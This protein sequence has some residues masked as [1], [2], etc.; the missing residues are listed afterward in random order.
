MDHSEFKD[1][2][3]RLQGRISKKNSESCTVN[4]TDE[5]SLRFEESNV[6][7]KGYLYFIDPFGESLQRKLVESVNAFQGTF[8]TIHSLQTCLTDEVNVALF[9]QQNYIHSKITKILRA[10]RLVERCV[11][12]RVCKHSL[13]VGRILESYAN[14]RRS[15]G[16]A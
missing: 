4:A 9:K 16:F 11:R 7:V 6:S 14:P 13:W 2:L 1:F 10:L 3:K 12:M 15:R 8:L 5:F